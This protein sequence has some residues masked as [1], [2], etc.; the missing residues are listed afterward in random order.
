[1]SM[2]VQQATW[3]TVNSP[4]VRASLRRI[5]IRVGSQSA[6]KKAG[7]WSSSIPEQQER[8]LICTMMQLYPD[9]VNLSIAKLR[10]IAGPA[11]SPTFEFLT[12]GP[13][14]VQRFRGGFRVW[15]LS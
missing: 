1:M 13:S 12:G 9:A 10:K 11:V 15:S 7:A 5:A 4:E 6:L 14:E 2:G 3:L 8:L